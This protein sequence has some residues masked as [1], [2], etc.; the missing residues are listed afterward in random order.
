MKEYLFHFAFENQCQD[1]YIT[2][3][4]WGSLASGTLPVYYGAPNVKEHVPPNSVIVADDFES[5]QD[6]ANHLVRLSTDRAL[7]E[8][9]HQW[10]YEPLDKSF[11]KKYAFTDTHSTCRMCRFAYATRHG[12]V[13]NHSMQEV[14]EPYISHNTCRNKVGLVGH[15]FKEYWLSSN[16]KP[17]AVSS[18][19]KTKTCKITTSNRAIDIDH[20]AVHRMVYNHDGVT[21]LYIDTEKEDENYILRLETPVVA[22]KFFQL[23]DNVRWLQ[24]SES[25]L[26]VL[27]SGGQQQQA[28]TVIQNGTVQIFVSTTM[29]VR[30][31][32]ENVDHFHKGARTVSSY[33][34]DLMV[35]DFLSPIQAYIEYDKGFLL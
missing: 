2:E 31:I 5:P 16:G 4:L 33:F 22:N 12:L 17:V 13:W 35:R 27:I 32:V 8:S 1:D 26:T 30:I 3:K 10:R 24:D 9:Y 14:Q 18:A 15:P 11:V 23:D 34:G 20:G 25:R 19:D 21:D 7:Y 6:L 29:R 28:P